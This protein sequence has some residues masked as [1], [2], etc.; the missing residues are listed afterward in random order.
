M[1]LLRQQ[2]NPQNWSRQVRFASHNSADWFLQRKSLMHA[3]SVGKTGPPAGCGSA[4]G[5]R[6]SSTASLV[7]TSVT[8]SVTSLPER[9]AS[10]L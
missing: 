4:V 10:V 5:K 6:V 2:V 1:P 7:A 3:C 8:T 9:R